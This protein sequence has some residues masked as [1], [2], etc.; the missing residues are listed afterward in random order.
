MTIL[1]A[2]IIIVSV[3]FNTG[4]IEIY[5]DGAAKPEVGGGL[6]KMGWVTLDNLY[7]PCESPEKFFSNL[8][9][10]QDSEFISYRQDTGSWCFV[11]NHFS[12]YGM[13]DSENEV[14]KVHS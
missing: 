13:D 11:V 8:S 9:E 2:I 1:P 10:E 5:P 6:N 12:K 14:M 3:F 7:P 4:S